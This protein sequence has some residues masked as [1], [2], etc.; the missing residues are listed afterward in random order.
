MASTLLTDSKIRGLKPK[1]SAYYTWQAAATRGTGRLGV[2]T[3]PSGR[4]V[5]VYRHFIRG[6]EKFVTLGDFPALTLAE[7]TSKARDA[8]DNIGKPAVAVIEH[9]TL[10]Q[11]FDDYIADQKKRGKR[12]WEKTQGRLNQ[13]LAST[14]IDGKDPAKDVTPDQIKHVLAEFIERGASADNDP[15]N[16]NKKSVY[17]MDRNPVAVIPAQRGVDKALDRFL[18]WDELA[19]L[20]R[21]LDAPPIALEINLDF[22]ELLKLCIHTAGQRPWE[23][24]TN[25]RDNWDKKSQTLTAPPH[26]SKNSDFHMIPLSDSA[27]KVLKDLEKRYPKS[28]FLFPAKTAEGHI[29]SAEFSKQVRRFCARTDFE[30]FT[31]RDIRRTFKTL[32]GDMG[33]SSEMRDRLQNHKKPGV[34]TKHYDRYDYLREKREIIE[35]WEARL[36][37]LHGEHNL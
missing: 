13:V 12:S 28:N 25:T 36:I 17:G 20:L 34:S 7:A 5:F 27:T 3:Y 8:A 9:A 32:A 23:L 33:V 19:E 31:P 2:K 18:S 15:A 14:H 6:K 37:D 4:K 1:T 22:A 30:K 29:L 10:K 24:M 11:L 21:L 35:Q 16:I 26:I